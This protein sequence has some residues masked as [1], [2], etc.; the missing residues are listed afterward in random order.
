MLKCQIFIASLLVSAAVSVKTVHV[1]PRGLRRA[2]NSQSAHSTSSAQ[3]KKMT[4]SVND[5][6][7]V[8]MVTRY[9][10]RAVVM[11]AVTF[12]LADQQVWRL[13]E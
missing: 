7:Q 6:W 9:F 13:S 10:V 12:S 3:Q 1:P 4:T 5:Q 8:A 11:S 2:V